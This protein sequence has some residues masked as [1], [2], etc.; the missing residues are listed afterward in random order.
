[1]EKNKGAADTRSP[2][3]TTLKELGITKNQSSRW[4]ALGRIPQE[5]FEAALAGDK[6]PNERNH[7]PMRYAEQDRA[8]AG[9]CA[10]VGGT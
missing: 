7:R 6:K 8:L 2:R 1:M 3:V 10:G 4:Q 9:P 5:D